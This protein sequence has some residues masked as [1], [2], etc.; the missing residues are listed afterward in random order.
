[1]FVAFTNLQKALIIFNTTGDVVA[2]EVGLKRAISLSEMDIHNRFLAELYLVKINNLFSRN[3]ADLNTET[4]K[5]EFQKSFGEAIKHA[6]R[7]IELNNNDY[8]NWVEAGRVYA[9][10]VPIKIAG[11]YESAL[12]N[13][14]KAL[15]LNPKSPLLYLTL[16]QLEL[17]KNDSKTARIAIGQA[18]QLKPDYTDAIFLLA[19]ID[20]NEGNLVEAIQSVEKVAQIAPNDPTVFFQLG[21]L[22]YNNKNYKKAVE[23]LERAVA[24]LPDYANARYFLGL[25]YYQIGKNSEAV[26]QFVEIQKNNSDNQEV[27]LILGNLRAGKSPFTDA[28]PPVDNKPESRSKPPITEPTPVE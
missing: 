4:A 13:Y 16:A 7:A 20:A 19:Q 12:T 3:A 25:S 9:T 1:K 5:A 26:K 18:L 8:Q 14:N 17:A 11:A 24:L 28:K 22:N 2:T 27:A 21:L 15:T 23:A 10:V 6:K